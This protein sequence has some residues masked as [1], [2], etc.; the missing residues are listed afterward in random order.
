VSI[1]SAHIPFARLVDLVEGRMPADEQARSQSHLSSCPRCGAEYDWLRRVIDLMRTDDSQD[2]PPHVV[3]RA[4]R[5]LRTQPEAPQVGLRQWFAALHFDSAQLPSAV[6][7]RA[8]QP[9]ERQLLFTAAGLDLDLRV[10]PAD[11]QWVVSGQVLGQ[12]VGGHVELKGPGA[13]QAPLNEL[14]E[15]R[16][17][18][19]A[20]GT[21]RL[22][23]RLADF[24]IVVEG[25]EVGT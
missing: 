12:D 2:A 17:S 23:L 14:S 4:A 22:T 10:T 21:Y 6:G 15:F 3:A 16:L 18:P 8:G 7:V 25:L 24:E 20:A 13:T 1:P 11:A 19:V 9:T 5:L